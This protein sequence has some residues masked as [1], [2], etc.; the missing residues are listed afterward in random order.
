L[1]SLPYEMLKREGGRLEFDDLADGKR[2]F[3]SLG[4]ELPP[5][6]QTYLD[7]GRFRNALVLDEVG[8]R[9]TPALRRF[10]RALGL[11]AYRPEPSPGQPTRPDAQGP[12]GRPGEA[13]GHFLG[14]RGPRSRMV[15]L[16]S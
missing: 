7:L 12:G 6:Y 10:I 9:P 5:L 15:P 8:R 3:K 11:E 13:S 14:A 2:S 16:S 1:R 4:I